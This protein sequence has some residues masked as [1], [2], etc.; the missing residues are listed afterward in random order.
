VLDW[1]TLFT[2]VK[3]LSVVVNMK[4]RE[5][6]GRLVTGKMSAYDWDSET[7]TSGVIL[8]RECVYYLFGGAS[9]LL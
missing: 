9:L 6:G 2:A 7:K 8:D 4:Y 3:L 1:R 5:S